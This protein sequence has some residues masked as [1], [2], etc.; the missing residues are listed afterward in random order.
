MNLRFLSLSILALCGMAHA[1]PASIG[2]A[3]AY[4]QKPV[5]IIVP[6]T[7][8]GATD[9]MARLLAA[10]FTESMGQQFIAENRAGA[11]G[12]VGAEL[13]SRAA[14]DGY[15]L[16][17]GQASNLAINQH[18]M[19]KIPYDPLT[20]FAPISLVATSPNLL[21]VHPSLPVRSVKDLIALA[22][23]K[24]GVIN[25]TSSGS[26]SPG[27]LAAEY[28]KKLA[29]I[30]MVHIPQKGAAPALL[31]VIAGHA[32]LYFTSP[33]SAQPHAK[34]GRI[35]QI[36]VTSAKRFAPLPDVPSVAEAGFPGFDISSWWGLLAPAGLPKDLQSRL[37]AETLKA[38]EQR[39]TKDKLTAQGIMVV[40][41]TPEQFAA[42][43][44]SEIANWSRIVAASGARLD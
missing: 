37:H 3:Q 17:V 2:A 33:I 28:L 22:K 21:V 9:I 1:Q 41:N 16:W 40:T 27:H 10:K 34:A 11:A 39:D 29:A 18:L 14:P 13:A 7:P 8:G 31:D 15:T 20:A 12:L 4:P 19:K 44:R 5:R 6:Y 38:V 30:D 25:Y 36:A 42:Y 43:I 32:D 24:P 23:A 26:G 35:R